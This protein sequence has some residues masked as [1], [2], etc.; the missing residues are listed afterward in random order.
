MQRSEDFEPWA[1]GRTDADR[2]HAVPSIGA[3]GHTAQRGYPVHENG[4]AGGNSHSDQRSLPHNMDL[5]TLPNRNYANIH[6]L[7]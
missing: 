2:P 3:Q 6:N 4:H 5:I 1:S 7:A